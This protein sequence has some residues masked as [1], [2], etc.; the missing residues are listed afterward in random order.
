[1]YR[2]FLL[3]LQLSALWMQCRAYA[4][5]VICPGFGNDCID[6]D[7]PLGQPSSVGLKSVLSR[8]GFPIEKIYT[9]PV[10]RADWIRVALGIFDI[11]RFYT[12]DCL[13]SGLGYGWYVQRLK[14]EVDRAY[15]ESGGE[16]V[17]LLAHSAGGWL[18]R[19]AMAD[20]VW[21]AERQLKT[22]DRIQCFVTLGAIHRV[23]EIN[24][25]SCVTRGA[26]KNTDSLYPGAFLKQFGIKYIAVGG[27]AVVGDDAQPPEDVSDIESSKV[28]ELYSKRGEGSSARV[29]YTSYQAVSGIGNLIGDGVVPLDWA[30]LDGAIKIT[31]DGVVHSINEAGTTIPSDRWYGSDNVIDR[32]LPVVLQEMGITNKTMK[33]YEISSLSSFPF[34]NLFSIFTNPQKSNQITR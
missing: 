17:L 22:S 21:C 29:A 8:R 26:L 10:K 1:M 7:K 28:D 11:P 9:V 23:P 15:E 14:D 25:E 33:S 19:A 24:P 16:K 30:H 18:A 4:P 32:W 6:Y 12:N 27:S 13:P 2:W 5:V 3:Q 20:G 31:L 34:S